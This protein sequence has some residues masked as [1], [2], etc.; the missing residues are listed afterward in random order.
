MTVFSGLFLGG[1]PPELRSP[2]LKVTLSSV[3]DRE[4]F[5]GWI[6]DVRVNYT[7]TSP[8]ESQEVRLD[9]EQSHL[10]ARDVCL[11][12]GV[13]S[14]L[15]NQAV[16]DCSHTGFRGKDC[17]EG[18]AHLMMGDQEHSNTHMVRGPHNKQSSVTN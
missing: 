1:L 8:V 5:K 4:P 12:G 10:C 17:S 18:L 3:K 14:V 13:C 16:C 2:T 7:Q 11:N 6:T 9:D 15:N